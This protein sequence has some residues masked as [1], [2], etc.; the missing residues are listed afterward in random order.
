M[1]VYTEVKKP[2][3]FPK[4]LLD[5]CNIYMVFNIAIAFPWKSISNY[6]RVDMSRKGKA[7]CSAVA[8]IMGIMILLSGAEC[9]ASGSSEKRLSDMERINKF[10][11]NEAVSDYL[12]RK[13]INSE[14]F[15]HKLEKADTKTIAVFATK[16]DKVQDELQLAQAQSQD[17]RLKEAQI[18]TLE[19]TSS[20]TDIVTW[21]LL[22]SLVLSLLM[23][24]I[25][26]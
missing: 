21:F 20:M 12:A 4:I 25:I 5:K 9:L 7:F 8:G 6:R 13:G 3:I 26:I 14:E 18:K 24:L 17:E 19:K 10:F 15:L 16:V 2:F 11:S 22:G 23:F 1:A